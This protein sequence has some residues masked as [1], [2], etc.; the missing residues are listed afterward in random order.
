MSLGNKEVAGSAPITGFWR[1]L[2]PLL[3]DIIALVMIG[4]SL[5][6]FLWKPLMALGA[7]G[8]WVGF[9][10][11]LLYFGLFNSRLYHGQTPGKMLMRIRVPMRTDVRLRC[12]ARY[13]ASACSACRTM[14]RAPGCP[15]PSGHS[16]R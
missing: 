2:L 1:R 8:R 12:G 16:S 3:I 15:L 6:L 14:C 13:S 9:A 11:S 5:C 4:L 7:G 10:I